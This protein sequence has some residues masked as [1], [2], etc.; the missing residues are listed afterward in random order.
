MKQF[1]FRLEPKKLAELK[2]AAQLENR[3]VGGL[4]RI[5]INNYLKGKS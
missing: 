1:T 3:S 4:L 2:L 5:I